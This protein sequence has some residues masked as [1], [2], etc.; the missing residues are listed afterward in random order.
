MTR[1]RR[2]TLLLALLPGALAFTLL[3]LSGTP[4][5]G[6][7]AP[8]VN[9]P[10]RSAPTIAEREPLPVARGIAPAA[11]RVADG[12]VEDMSEPAAHPGLV[13]GRDR[14]ALHVYVDAVAQGPARPEVRIVAQ[15]ER[16]G[17]G[18]RVVLHTALPRGSVRDVLLTGPLGRVTF[19]LLAGRRIR[20]QLWDDRT[21]AGY[22]ELDVEPLSNK[23]E[24]ELVVVW[25]RPERREVRGVVLQ[26]ETGNPIGGAQVLLRER[27]E[28]LAEVRTDREGR[29]VF[30]TEAWRSPYVAVQGF[31]LTPEIAWA[32][33]GELEIRLRDS[34]QVLVRAF[35]ADGPA[36]NVEVALTADALAFC[37]DPLG[38]GP[39]YTGLDPT[40]LRFR[41]SGTTGANGT[42][43]IEDVPSNVTVTAHLVAP[44]REE[45]VATFSIVPRMTY[46]LKLARKE[47][48]VLR[49]R[50]VDRS[51]RPIG[52]N[53]IW[54]REASG[55]DVSRFFT[56][57]DAGASVVTDAG[58]YFSF[59]AWQG[60]YLVGPAPRCAFF[61]RTTLNPNELGPVAVPV[62]VPGEETVEI[63]LRAD[64]DVRVRGTVVDEG[65][66]PVPFAH[67]LIRSEAL[68]EARRVQANGAGVFESAP[69]ALGTYELDALSVE[70]ERAV[71]KPYTVSL[72]RR[73]SERPEELE[74][75]VRRARGVIRG[76]VVAP[77]TKA[78]VAATV[79]ASM[80][81]TGLPWSSDPHALRFRDLLGVVTARTDALTGEFVLPDLIEGEYALEVTGSYRQ[82]MVPRTRH[83]SLATGETEVRDVFLELRA[84]ATLSFSELE[85]R[86]LAYVVDSEGE[87]F[88]SGAFDRRDRARKRTLE[89]P[90]GNLRVEV[91]DAETGALWIREL[92]LAPGATHELEVETR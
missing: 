24:R 36:P 20:L 3:W 7:D 49:G 81:P 57:D 89:V 59:A 51:G 74:L 84:V 29:F 56:C 88:A 47:R 67:V 14:G 13:D 46:T 34:S 83:I 2:P 68:G 55:A 52:G 42:C 60:A 53:V 1:P 62:F 12:V 35:G 85:L 16:I 86:A 25:D 43:L 73:E 6:A 79:R 45:D 78:S 69:L 61:E 31:G 40:W 80:Q 18:R 38:P 72:G 30:V 23:E 26:H 66:R 71:S 63:V 70:P 41:T 32:R 54:L 15:T 27:D 8:V 77:G 75:V 33:E 4:E 19:D 44:G 48:G 58:G 11:R 9:A 92:T 87:R 37:D 90:A 21:G 76:Y 28:G 64:R 5:L 17:A 10:R 22:R 65:R 39:S 82:G 50:L 91:R